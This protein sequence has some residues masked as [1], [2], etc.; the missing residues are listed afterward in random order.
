MLIW[1]NCDSFA[2][3]YLMY[4]ACFKKFNFQEKLCFI[5][6]KDRAWELDPFQVTVLV[7]FFDKIFLC[8]MT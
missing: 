4:V 3:T 2:N 5:L 6:C 8:N 1:T 7:E